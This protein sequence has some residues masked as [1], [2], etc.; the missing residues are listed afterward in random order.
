MVLLCS[1]P[2]TFILSEELRIGELSILNIAFSLSLIC[3]K[4]SCELKLLFFP[5][6]TSFFFFFFFSEK[7]L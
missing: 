3:F 1:F 7:K 4:K 5:S 2:K 6:L